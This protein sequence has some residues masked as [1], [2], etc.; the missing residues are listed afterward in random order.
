MIKQSVFNINGFI[1]ECE[2]NIDIEIIKEYVN[3]LKRVQHG[4]IKAFADITIEQLKKHKCKTMLD[5]GCGHFSP[6]SPRVQEEID[7]IGIDLNVAELESARK[8]YKDVILLDALKALDHFGEKS[9]DAV[10]SFDFLEHLIKEDSIKLVNDCEKIAKKIVVFFI[11]LD[12][13]NMERI[14][15]HVDELLMAHK[16]EWTF[17]EFENMGYETIYI[18]GPFNHMLVWKDL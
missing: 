17:E 2:C 16:C 1:K 5:I 8:Y 9:F 18:N 3:K 10:I 12:A 7:V 13:V 15:E 14:G 11:P 6:P 4:E